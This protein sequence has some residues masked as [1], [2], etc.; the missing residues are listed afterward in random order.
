MSETKI[1]TSVKEVTFD[2]VIAEFDKKPEAEVPRSLTA[3]LDKPNPILDG[4]LGKKDEVKVEDKDKDVKVED[5]DKTEVKIDD[6][7]LEIKKEDKAPGKVEIKDIDS[8]LD[9]TNED[10]PEGDKK[11]DQKTLLS[12]LEQLTKEEILLPFDEDKPLDKYTAEDIK[13]L[14]KANIEHQKKQA[15][16]TEI[17][18]FFESLPQEIQYAAKYVADGGTDLKALFKALAATEEIKSLDTKQLRDRESII[19]EYYRAIDWGTEDEITEEVDR[20]KELGETE[21]E[22]MANKYKPKLEKMHD[23]VTKQHLS[24][25]QKAREIQEQ[26]MDAYL[27]NAQQAIVTGKVGGV[28]LDKKTQ[29]ALWA[30]LTQPGYQTRRGATTNK[31]GHLLEKYQYTEPNFELM[32]E[33]LWLLDDPKGYKEAMSKEL[34]NEHVS[35]TV[36]VLKTEQ[37]KKGLATQNDKPE[38]NEI[39]RKTIPKNVPSFLS[40]LKQ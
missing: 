5:K 27:E 14:V 39:K 19:R 33:A 8:V 29:A 40:G 26:E 34:K 9:R 21:L 7:P 30:G 2:D 37:G 16:D 32:Y 15:L 13:E 12:A 6:K 24:R 28:Q 18:E 3:N 17:G 10:E 38:G 25:Q 1:S 22:K 20:V 36:R 31:L 11:T 23:E 4:P 35:T